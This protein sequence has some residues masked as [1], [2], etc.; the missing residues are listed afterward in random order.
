VL[1]L[2][3]VSAFALIAGFRRRCLAGWLLLGTGL[4]FTGILMLTPL[5]APDRYLLVPAVSLHALA[6]LGIAMIVELV[7]RNRGIPLRRTARLAGAAAALGLVWVAAPVY[8]SMAIDAFD[9]AD[10]RAE[11]IGWA[12]ATLG[13]DT[14]LAA[15]RSVGLPGVDGREPADPAIRFERV[16]VTI[17]N[18]MKMDPHDLRLRGIT[19]IILR[20]REL[21]QYLERSRATRG[22]ADRMRDPTIEEPEVVWRT[23]ERFKLKNRWLRPKLVVLRL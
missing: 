19:H 13:D 8:R 15:S 14:K 3:G 16:P 21:R 7:G 6:G 10:V 5:R 17:D 2:A 22:P 18:A 23:P 20:D 1:L 11:L 4:L 12:N 9:Q